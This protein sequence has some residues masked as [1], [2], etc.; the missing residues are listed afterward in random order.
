[1]LGPQCYVGPD[2]DPNCLQWLLA[3]ETSRQRFKSLHDN[4]F[5]PFKPN[6]LSHCYQLDQSISI[7]WVVGMVFFI[8]FQFLIE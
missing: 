8:F 7:L 3:G 6:E 2:L 5:N 1:M 4:F